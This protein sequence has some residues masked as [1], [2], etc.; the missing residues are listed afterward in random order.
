MTPTIANEWTEFAAGQLV[1]D[2]I[3]LRTL[4][5]RGAD[6]YST[7]VLTELID[8]AERDAGER[9]QIFDMRLSRELEVL[10]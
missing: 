9:A 8:E 1:V 4:E 10:L 5:E 7:K 6:W 3:H 2:I